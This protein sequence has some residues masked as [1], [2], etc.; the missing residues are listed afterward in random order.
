VHSGYGG[1]SRR[2]WKLPHFSELHPPADLDHP[3][4]ERA[5]EDVGPRALADL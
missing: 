5:G 3:V 1:R 2:H 4:A